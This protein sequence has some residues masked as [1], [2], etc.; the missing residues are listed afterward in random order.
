MLKGK[1]CS[2]IVSRGPLTALRHLLLAISLWAAPAWASEAIYRF[3]WV[4]GDGYSMTGAVSFDAANARGLLTQDDV[5]CFEISGF[6]NGARIG[7]WRLS[8]KTDTTPWRLHFLPSQDRFLVVGDG[9]PMPQAWNMD[10]DGLGCGKDG[11]GFNLGNIAQD[12]C[13]DETLLESSQVDPLRPFP[14]TRVARHDFGDGACQ[15]PLLLGALDISG[16]SGRS[17]LSR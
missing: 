1:T 16:V 13:L 5:I 17:G 14:A 12:L 4:G 8:Q 7:G 6:R 9:I 3:D 11:F 2:V 10:G 15:G